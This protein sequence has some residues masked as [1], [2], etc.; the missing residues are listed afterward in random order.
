GMGNAPIAAVEDEILDTAGGFVLGVGDVAA[1]QLARLA[2]GRA[3]FV[4]RCRRGCGEVQDC[5]CLE[6]SGGET[7]EERDEGDMFH[8]H[9]LLFLD[10]APRRCSASASP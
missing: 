5:L 2:A 1:D 8:E 7:G 3:A 10:V 6:G 4:E 9:C